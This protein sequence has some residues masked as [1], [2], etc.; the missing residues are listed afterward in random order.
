[1]GQPPASQDDEGDRPE[2]PEEHRRFA[3]P[4]FGQGSFPPQPEVGQGTFSPQPGFGHAGFGQASAPPST[5]RFGSGPAAPTGGGAGPDPDETA[6]IPPVAGAVPATPYRAP[7]HPPE[8]DSGTRPLVV[9]GVIAGALVLLALIGLA[10]WAI[11][12]SSDDDRDD[13]PTAT[14]ATGGDATQ[15]STT[16]PALSDPDALCEGDLCTTLAGAVGSIHLVTDPDDAGTVLAEWELEGSWAEYDSGDPAQL[17]GATATYVDAL[18]DQSLVLTAT[19]FDTE[20]E[21]EAFHDAYVAENGEP[22]GQGPVWPDGSGVMA[23]YVDGDDFRILWYDDTAIA[24]LIEG[25]VAEDLALDFY[26]SLGF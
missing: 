20:D 11:L 19:S 3:A 15:E 12:G 25:P 14:A 9:V 16:Q 13:D 23:Y 4:E 2:V 7:G 5:F 1:M 17:D 6:Q 26:L 21:T 24:Y 10:I 8:G 18:S 22:V